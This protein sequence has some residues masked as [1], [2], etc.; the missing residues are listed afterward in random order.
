M[1]TVHN[2]TFPHS[3]RVECNTIPKAP[4]DPTGCSED[5]FTIEKNTWSES[6]TWSLQ[7]GHTIDWISKPL[8]DK[9]NSSN[10]LFVNIIVWYARQTRIQWNSNCIGIVSLIFIN[11]CE[12][13]M[14]LI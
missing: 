3:E 2:V 7:I 1:N 6:S 5:E 10:Y 12:E 8:E 11:R 13:G 14:L 4:L 9:W